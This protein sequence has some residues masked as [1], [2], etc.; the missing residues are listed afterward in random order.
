MNK[1][2]NND[3]LPT[4]E[5]TLVIKAAKEDNT[6]EQPNIEPK[7]ECSNITSTKAEITCDMN[8]RTPKAPMPR[9]FYNETE[10]QNK[11]QNSAVEYDRKRATG[12]NERKSNIPMA[13]NFYRETKTQSSIC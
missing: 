8:E 1:M 5:P 7:H 13:R 12:V 6:L 2:A 4:Q 11:Y 10:T 3:V 9:F